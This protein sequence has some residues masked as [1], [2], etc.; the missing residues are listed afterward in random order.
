MFNYEVVFKWGEESFDHEFTLVKASNSFEAIA[1]GIRQAKK[2]YRNLPF[3]M[4]K[5][6]KAYLVK[7]HIVHI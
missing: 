5:I 7:A 1:K 3:T 6:Q 4:E 2:L